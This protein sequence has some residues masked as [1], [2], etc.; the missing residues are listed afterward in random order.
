MQETIP[1]V[2]VFRSSR[3]DCFRAVCHLRSVA[4]IEGYHRPRAGSIKYIVAREEG[5]GRKSPGCPIG[6][7]RERNFCNFLIP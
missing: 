5:V 1:A 6:T 4:R 7:A 2:A 3:S